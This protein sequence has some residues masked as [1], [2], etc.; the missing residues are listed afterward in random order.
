MKRLVLPDSSSAAKLCYYV[1]SKSL[2]LWNGLEVTRKHYFLAL[3]PFSAVTTMPPSLAQIVGF[4]PRAAPGFYLE[5]YPDS[6]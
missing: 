4:C 1:A 2:C 6:N 5:L 3:T